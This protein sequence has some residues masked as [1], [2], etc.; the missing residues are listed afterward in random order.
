MFQMPRPSAV[1]TSRPACV[2][3]SEGPPCSHWLLSVDY[4]HEFIVVQLATGT[5]TYESHEVARTA[6]KRGFGEN[7]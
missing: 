6:V 1:W 7:S 3:S 2:R 4:R 5:I